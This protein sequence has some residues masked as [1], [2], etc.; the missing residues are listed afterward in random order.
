MHSWTLPAGHHHGTTTTTNAAMTM[1]RILF[2]IAVFG[3]LILAGCVTDSTTPS[4]PLPPGMTQEDANAVV[5][6]YAGLYDGAKDSFAHGAYRDAATAFSK[7][8]EP[9]NYQSATAAFFDNVADPKK[10]RAMAAYYL[11]QCGVKLGDDELAVKGGAYAYFLLQGNIPTLNW[12]AA[13]LQKRRDVLDRGEAGDSEE[14]PWAPT[15]DVDLQRAEIQGAEDAHRL[16]ADIYSAAGVTP[17]TNVTSDHQLGVES[18]GGLAPTMGGANPSPQG[19][20]STAQVT[21]TNPPLSSRIAVPDPA[22]VPA[23][24]PVLP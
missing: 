13:Q 9:Q 1:K 7:V 19:L 6:A 22:L 10:Q 16:W 8:L 18:S 20:P 4:I 2:P 14:G 15:H 11:L 5:S 21:G 23:A 17:V 24:A 3:S 12:I